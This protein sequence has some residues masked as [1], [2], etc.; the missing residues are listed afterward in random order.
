MGIADIDLQQGSVE[1]QLA[2]VG[3]LGAASVHDALAKLKKGEWAA[4][5]ERTMERLMAERLSGIPAEGYM[6]TYLIWGIEKEPEARAQYILL[7]LTAGETL[8]QVGVVRHPRIKGS[9]ASPD[10]FVGDHGLVEIKCLKTINHV[11]A[12]TTGLVPEEYMTQMQWQMACTGRHW[13]DYVSYDP[14]VAPALQLFVTRVPRDHDMIQK[15]EFGVSEFINELQARLDAL[16]SRYGDISAPPYVA[17]MATG[18][19]PIEITS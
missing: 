17:P 8:R 18:F 7:R 12:L 19:E 2:R 9:H 4:S 14:R 3:S 15:L 13:C 16:A 11:A 10:G 6:T 5:R 1:W